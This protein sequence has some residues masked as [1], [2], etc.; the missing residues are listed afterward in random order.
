MICSRASVDATKIYL[1]QDPK[2]AM[3]HKVP[4][5]YAFVEIVTEWEACHIYKV[6]LTTI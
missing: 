2:A 1:G 6:V 4:I 3:A 5:G